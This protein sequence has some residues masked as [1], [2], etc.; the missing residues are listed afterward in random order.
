MV[1]SKPWDPSIYN[2]KFTIGKH[3][4]SLLAI[5]TGTCDNMYNQEGNIFFSS[6]VNGSDDII[7][8][9]ANDYS[10]TIT[11]YVNDYANSISSVVL[12]N[13]PHTLEFFNCCDDDASSVASYQSSVHSHHRHSYTKRYWIPP[14][15]VR[16]PCTNKHKSYRLFISSHDFLDENNVLVPAFLNCFH[17]SCH[18][19]LSVSGYD[20]VS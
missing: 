11:Y 20:L 1:S 16:P 4:L 6:E 15:K 17:I 3:L 9:M 5:P 2:T 12:G 14:P 8:S 18:I 13:D 19:P 10:N 7:V